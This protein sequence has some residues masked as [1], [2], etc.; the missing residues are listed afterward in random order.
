MK[1]ASVK[2]DTYIDYEVEHIKNDPNFKVGNR[3][4]IS[5]GLGLKT[6]L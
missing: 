5:K 6:S 4:K 3:V 1:A 2:V